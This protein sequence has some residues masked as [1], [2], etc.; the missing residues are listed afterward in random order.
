MKE[1]E[2]FK[3]KKK[4]K[5]E[6]RSTNKELTYNKG[7]V[8]AEHQ[9]NDH[10]FKDLMYI[11]VK[12]IIRRQTVCY[13]RQKSFQGKSNVGSV[14]PL[15][16][17]EQDNKLNRKSS[18]SVGSDAP[19]VTSDLITSNNSSNNANESGNR[20]YSSLGGL[21][22][23]TAATT[24]AIANATQAHAADAITLVN[25]TKCTLRK[26][27]QRQSTLTSGIHKSIL[28]N[29]IVTNSRIREGIHRTSFATLATSKVQ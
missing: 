19:Y 2:K 12:R 14:K 10:R 17:D 9:K 4:K 26:Q 28:N 29:D 23:S 13:S 11:K 8:S 21:N 18:P 7:D 15:S 20:L 5:T 16:N 3:K 24:A 27:R 1:K 25:S 22:K 6:K